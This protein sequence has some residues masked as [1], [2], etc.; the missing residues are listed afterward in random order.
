MVQLTLLAL[1]L[2]LILL[3]HVVGGR[4]EDLWEL[5]GGACFQGSGTGSLRR[6]PDG[7]EERIDGRQRSAGVLIPMCSWR[8]RTRA[9]PGQGSRAVEST[10]LRSG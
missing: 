2:Q 3:S 5:S 10:L 4:G 1:M 9:W 8:S 6:R 7:G